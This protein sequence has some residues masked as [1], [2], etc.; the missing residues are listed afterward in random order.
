MERINKT[1]N[2]NNSRSYRNGLLPF[3]RNGVDGNIEYVTNF[4]NGNY[5]Q[6]VCD[7]AV[8]S[9]SG[10]TRLRYLDVIRN[11]NFIQEQLK[12]GVFVKKYAY[13]TNI[14]CSENEN[15]SNLNNSY[16]FTTNFDEK[17]TKNKYEY[18]V[19]SE[20]YRLI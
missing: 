4:S 9:D 18:I 13:S 2:I 3:V 1:I 11:Y 17:D 19:I 15:H 5:G 14:V 16:I 12:D 10:E 8:Y 7:F 6:Y 20:R